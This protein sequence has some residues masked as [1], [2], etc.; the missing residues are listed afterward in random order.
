MKAFTAMINEFGYQPLAGFVG[1][2]DIDEFK[3]MATIDLTWKKE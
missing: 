2:A 3:Q 1:Q